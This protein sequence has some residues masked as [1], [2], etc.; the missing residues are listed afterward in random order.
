MGGSESNL[1]KTVARKEYF[2]PEERQSALKT[3]HKLAKGNENLAINTLEKHIANYLSP[4]AS[5]KLVGIVTKNRA[6]LSAK[7]PVQMVPC[8]S[9][10]DS[11][12]PLLKGS[13][14]EHL[15]LTLTLAGGGQAGVDSDAIIRYLEMMM[16]SYLRLATS[17][18]GY[19]SWHSGSGENVQRICLAILHDLLYKGAGP[20][21]TWKQLTPTAKFTYEEIEKFILSHTIFTTIETEVLRRCFDLSPP[22]DHT[23][24]L[25]LP[26]LVPKNFSGILSGSQVLLLNNSLPPPL[27]SEWRLLFSSTTH[28]SS[29]S[30]LLKQIVGKGPTLVVVEDQSGNKFGGFASVSWQ[31]RPQFQG[32][33]ECFLFSLEPRAGIFLTTGYNTNYMYLNYLEKNTMPNGLGMGGREELFGLWVDYD[34]GKGKTSPSCTT[35]RSPPLSPNTELD[36]AGLEVWGLGPEEVDSDE[37]EGARSKRSALDKNPEA[38]A[39]LDMMGKARVSEGLRE[40]EK[41]E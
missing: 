12:G 28:G 21:E 17:Q 26:S 29:F 16:S 1:S 33:A 3:L 7:N 27:R 8:T 25:P 22:A 14:E 19:R 38:R 37:E 10:V 41:D 36:I 40:D 18:K 5:S 31:V 11:L 32:T 2:T 39:M 34:F 6:S 20:K 30:I 35:F 23:S 9:V 24:L 15:Y 13:I 4:E